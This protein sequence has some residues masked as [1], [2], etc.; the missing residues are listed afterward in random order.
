MTKINLNDIKQI[1]GVGFGTSGIRDLNEKLTDKTVYLYTKAFMNILNETTVVIA[2]DRRICTNKIMIAVSKAVIDSGKQVINCG[3][4]PTP[5]VTFFGINKSC[6]SIM[7]TGSHI[8][9]DRNGVKFQL[10]TREIL[11]SDEELITNSEVI[12]DENLFDSNGNFI[13]EYLL[14]KETTQAYELYCRRYTDFFGTE[15]L[16]D[17]RIGVWGHSA[18]GRDLYVDL[19]TRL[20]ATV[21]KI[22]YSENKFVPVDT[23]TVNED[24]IEKMKKW[25][26]EYNLDYVISTDGD[27]DRPL[28]T[29]E[30]GLQVRSELL[31]IFASKL[32]N[33]D[34]L[35]TTVTACTVVEKS[36]Y[37]TKITRTP[38][39]SPHIVK[40]MIDLSNEGF[41]H[42]A[43]YELNGGFF[44]HN[45]FEVSGHVITSLPTRDAI[46]PILGTIAL[47]KLENMG[48][49]QMVL[50]LPSR[51]TYSS[52]IKGIPTDISL[53]VLANWI[54]YRS[55]IENVFGKIIDINLLDGLRLT[56]DNKNVVHFRP[57]K[58]APEFRNYTESNTY[59]NAKSIS[60]KA[61]D[62]IQNWTKVDTM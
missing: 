42:V 18:V 50:S 15:L 19:F 46:L 8:P 40:A 26:E 62:L 47:A 36:G 38:V 33:V 43:G 54:N 52:S 49:S 61:I 7:V 14:P 6:P 25:D 53:N 16:I 5:A 10:A 11:K 59:E 2:G 22:E 39:G 55:D 41:K 32:L 4:I 45:D 1:T 24:T 31:P 23:D 29:D 34:A 58:N 21:V 13:E 48:I 3:L 57:S 35:A 17:K 20:G 37:V 28:L 56:F 9:E 12:F 27:G 51:F 60:Q 30:N 44:L